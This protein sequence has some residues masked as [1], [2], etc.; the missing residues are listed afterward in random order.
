ME[1]TIKQKEAL[2]NMYNALRWDTDIIYNMTKEEASKEIDKTKTHIEEY[3]FPK[4]V[5]SDGFGHS[6]GW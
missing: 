6:A 2:I 1:I 5:E 4:R 3:G